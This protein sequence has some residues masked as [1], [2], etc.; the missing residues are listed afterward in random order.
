VRIPTSAANSI[1]YFTAAYLALSANYHS[2]T[3]PVTYSISVAYFIAA[4]LA[5]RKHID[6]PVVVVRYVLTSILALVIATAI[7]FHGPVRISLWAI[8]ALGLIWA[9]LYWK[10]KSAWLPGLA[11]VVIALVF[12]VGKGDA[13]SA[14]NLAT[15]HPIANARFVAFLT[16]T[17]VMAIAAMLFKSSDDSDASDI[18]AAFSYGWPVVLF[19]GLTVETSD[20]MRK[21]GA[22]T[23]ARYVAMSVLWLVYSL[24]LIWGGIR[25]RAEPV[26]EIGVISLFA[27][28]GFLA[29][30]AWH[31]GPI[32]NFDLLLNWRAGAILL[33]AA[34]VLVERLWFL[35]SK[36]DVTYAEG[37]GEVLVVI[38]GLLGMHLLTTETLDFFRHAKLVSILGA[39]PTLGVA[40]TLGVVWSLYSLALVAGAAARKRGSVLGLGLLIGML[41]MGTVACLG[42][43]FVPAASF[44]LGLNLR[45]GAFAVVVG[46]LFVERWIAVRRTSEYSWLV[47]AEG[48][49]DTVLAILGFELLTVE[50]LDWFGAAMAHSA[51]IFGVAAELARALTLSVVWT[52]YSLLL[53][54]LGLRRD[55]SGLLGLGIASA[56]VGIAAA[57]IAGAAFE[58]IRS[59]TPVLNYRAA[60]LIAAILG[61]V[62]ISRWTRRA[63]EGSWQQAV[64]VTMA[65]VAA[66]LGAELISAEI[67]DYCRAAKA[68]LVFGLDAGLARSFMLAMGWAIYSVPLLILS[69]EKKLEPVLYIT[70]GLVAIGLMTAF[71]SGFDY[72]PLQGFAPIANLRFIA[73]VTVALAMYAHQAVLSRRA[74]DHEWITRTLTVYRIAVSVLIY[75]LLTMEVWHYYERAGLL[76]PKH[77]HNLANQR[78]LALSIVWMLYSIVLMIIGIW[79]RTLSLRVVAIVLFYI[80]IA[81]LFISDLAFLDTLYRALSFIAVAPILF[82]TSYLYQRYKTF[83]FGVDEGHE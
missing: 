25:R 80:T 43:Q 32:A 10:M 48:A 65:A 19:L 64:G 7:Q 74:A 51:V 49:F 18:A 76:D 56:G 52:A 79:R 16:L 37:L 11:L 69:F 27:G 46:T 8:E 2:W 82:A 67:I 63:G 6:N 83:I 41:G 70:F 20:W 31:Y 28:V 44:K 45:A 72:R 23:Q 14:D 38:A 50:T 60:T 29:T 22:T 39:G 26:I 58:P 47:G 5:I 78:Q 68:G 42:A 55:S 17:I 9:G 1:A 33:A 40:M 81:K 36:E 53:S 75:Q 30:N 21:V 3:A 15:I 73:M 4:I 57:A 77:L 24:P 61:T 59:F 71:A 62:L 12:F 66:L 54:A 35:G 34:I 13:L